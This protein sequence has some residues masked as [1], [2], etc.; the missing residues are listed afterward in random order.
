MINAINKD[1]AKEWENTEVI[2][3]PLTDLLRTRAKALIQ[4]A[5]EAELQSFLVTILRSL[6]WRAV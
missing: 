1:K 3:D 2:N 5:V 6:I 4:Q